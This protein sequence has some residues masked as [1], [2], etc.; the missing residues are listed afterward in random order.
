MA[1]TTL[2]SNLSARRTGIGGGT[3]SA[4]SRQRRDRAEYLRAWRAARIAQGICVSCGQHPATHGHRCDLC[5]EK[6]LA[7]KRED[8]QWL[9]EHNLCIHCHKEPRYK[10]RLCKSCWELREIG[11]LVY[12]LLVT[13]PGRRVCSRC[14]IRTTGNKYRWC[15]HCRAEARRR[16]R[17]RNYRHRYK[18]KFVE[19]AMRLVGVA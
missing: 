3:S 19:K 2:D 10:D 16:W 7:Q 9:R 6:H 17:V 4:P 14:H 11:R 15:A 5:W 13:G 12:A 8:W 18:G 1:A